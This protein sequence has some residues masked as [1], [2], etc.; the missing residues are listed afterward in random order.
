MKA[1]FRKNLIFLCILLLNGYGANFAYSFDNL[2]TSDHLTQIVDADLDVGETIGSAVFQIS[3]QSKPIP[4]NRILGEIGDTEEEENSE[5]E[6]YAL[7]S[8]V[9]GFLAVFCYAHFLALLH[10]RLQQLAIKYIPYL[11]NPPLR[12]FIRFQVFRI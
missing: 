11:L 2:T 3:D 5:N 8:A 6:S 4:Q 10:E 12:K 9:D 7:G 1:A